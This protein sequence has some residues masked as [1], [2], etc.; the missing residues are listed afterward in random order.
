VDN[1]LEEPS[2]EFKK[3]SRNLIV[4]P[5]AILEFM[6]GD[7]KGMTR[8]VYKVTDSKDYGL[9]ARK[10]SVVSTESSGAYYIEDDKDIEYDWKAGEIRFS[11]NGVDYRI[12]AVQP[13]EQLFGE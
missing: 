6:S 3:Q 10:L 1:K 2:K 11:S 7:N 5:P 8:A 4:N 13:N 12:R 9:P